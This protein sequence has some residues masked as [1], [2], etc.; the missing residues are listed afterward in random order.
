MKK[1]HWEEKKTVAETLRAIYPIPS[2]EK[3]ETFFQSARWQDAAEAALYAPRISWMQFLRIQVHYIR[4]W[5]WILSAAVFAAALFLTLLPAQIT[6]AQ[7]PHQSFTA[8][9]FLSA[10]IPFLALATVTEAGYSARCGMEELELSTRFSLHAV[11]CARLG[12]LGAENL[13]LLGILLPFGVCLW[14]ADL[15]LLPC[16]ADLSH[17]KPAGAPARPVLRH[18]PCILAVR[19]FPVSAPERVLRRGRLSHIP[20]MA[21]R[22][23]IITGPGS[24]H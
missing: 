21:G 3:K 18:I 13:L 2:P 1:K 10:C 9:A 17:G 22:R 24:F 19:T 12:I 8:S 15:V 11:L 14:E 5:N 7:D 16:Q 20:Q 6:G 4:K 23:A